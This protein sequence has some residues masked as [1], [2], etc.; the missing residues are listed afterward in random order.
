MHSQTKID[1]AAVMPGGFKASGVH[2]GVK[3]SAPDLALISSDSPC[4]SARPLRAFTTAAADWK[5]NPREPSW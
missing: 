2:C 1:D 4:E 3:P 5:R